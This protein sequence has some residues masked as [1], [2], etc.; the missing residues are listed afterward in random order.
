MWETAREKEDTD[1]GTEK[2]SKHS[3]HFDPGLVKLRPSI[4]Y[5]IWGILLSRI[6]SLIVVTRTLR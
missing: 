4:G 3:T 1:E 6:S 5:R 2:E